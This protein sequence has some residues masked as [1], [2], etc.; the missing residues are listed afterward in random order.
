MGEGALYYRGKVAQSR[1]LL[2]RVTKI[3]Q[4]HILPIIGGSPHAQVR[5]HQYLLLIHF[6]DIPG[7]RGPWQPRI[8]GNLPYGD[9]P[10]SVYLLINGTG[11]IW[12]GEG[13]FWV[14]ERFIQTGH[15]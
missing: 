14:S 9:L 15:R 11:R 10:F 3:S 12:T 8:L 6:T 5:A 4:I 7:G 1:K 2:L 13:C